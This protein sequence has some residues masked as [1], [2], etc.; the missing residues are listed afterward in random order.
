MARLK[1]LLTMGPAEQRQQ[2]RLSFSAYRNI[3]NTKQRFYN[4]YTVIV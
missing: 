2:E 1:L 4:I 3:R